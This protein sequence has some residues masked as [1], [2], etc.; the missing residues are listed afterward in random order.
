[1]LSVFICGFISFQHI[2]QRRSFGFDIDNPCTLTLQVSYYLIQTIIV[3]LSCERDLK[4]PFAP[5]AVMCTISDP[6][7][8]SRGSLVCRVA[9]M[10][11]RLMIATRAHSVST[12]ARLCDV[13][14]IVTGG[15]CSC[16]RSDQLSHS[17]RRQWIERTCRFVKQQHGRTRQHRA[18]DCESLLVSRRKLAKTTLRATSSSSSF[19]KQILDPLLCARSDNP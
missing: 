10:L 11:P 8:R 5:E 13:K 17:R 1:M 4:L 12:S 2:K 9:R 14:R 15:S 6:D 19:A 16:K 3:M 7:V 18:R